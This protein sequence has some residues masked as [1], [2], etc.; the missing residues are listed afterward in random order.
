MAAKNYL[1]NAVTATGPGSTFTP[2]GGVINAQDWTIACWGTF[3]TGGSVK[4]EATHDGT[5]WFDTGIVFTA[6]GAQ[7]LFGKFAGL[8]G[9]VTAGSGF[10]L[11]MSIL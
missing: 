11:S 8:R 4:V 5:T 10:T 7:N 2:G 3:G 1:L 9:N 6:A